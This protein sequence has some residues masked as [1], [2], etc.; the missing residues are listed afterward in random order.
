MPGTTDT[1]SLPYDLLSENVA[2]ATETGLERLAKA[3]ATELD[4]ADTARV[5]ALKRAA[6]RASRFLTVQSIPNNATTAITFD[7]ENF[8]SHAMVNLGTN[9]QR[10]TITAGG[11]AG[12]YRVAAHLDDMF[13]NNSGKVE[14]IL[15][16]NGSELFRQTQF[17]EANGMW[18]GGISDCI[19]GD[20]FGVSLFQNSGAARDAD[21]IRLEVWKISQ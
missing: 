13:T 17:A 18:V 6:A 12:V 4:S 19:V 14:I 3:I 21:T 11:G 16:K 10:I 20:F 9:A 15:T 1:Q 7:T 8:D 2:T 5:A